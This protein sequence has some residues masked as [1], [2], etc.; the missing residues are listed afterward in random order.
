MPVK[1]H[2]NF[3]GTEQKLTEQGAAEHEKGFNIWH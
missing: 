2:I 1:F 3:C